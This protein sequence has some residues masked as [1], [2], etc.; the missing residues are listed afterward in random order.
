MATG[1]SL[2]I[3]AVEFNAD[4]CVETAFKGV[5]V[6]GIVVVVN[7]GVFRLLLLVIR[8]FGEF[9]KRFILSTKATSCDRST[10]TANGNAFDDDGCCDVAGD[11]TSPS[12]LPI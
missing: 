5:V 6:I 4:D 1:R 3:F 7:C 2:V 11:A 10:S 12:N 8:R 9:N